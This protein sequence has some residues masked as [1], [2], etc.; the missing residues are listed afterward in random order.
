[1][2]KFADSKTCSY[3]SHGKWVSVPS[4]LVQNYFNDVIKILNKLKPVGTH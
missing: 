3:H 1:M 2:A 4:I